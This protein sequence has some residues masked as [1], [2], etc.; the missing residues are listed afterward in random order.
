MGAELARAEPCKQGH[1][2]S[3]S[4]HDGKRHRCRPCHRAW[5]RRWQDAATQ[6]YRQRW[7]EAERVKRE[8]PLTPDQCREAAALLA[9]HATRD[10]ATD[11]LT[12]DRTGAG[13]YGQ[14]SLW[15]RQL[16]H[17]LAWEVM[18]GPIP[19]GLVTDH[20]CRN[21]ACVEV[22][23][24]RIVTRDQ[25]NRNVRPGGRLGPIWD[26]LEPNPYSTTWVS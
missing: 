20:L 5:A 2:P 22:E 25:N 17:R 3:L 14:V 23:H 21:R 1:D 4:Y 15:G 10:A 8:T 7:A 16:A 11:C 19:D 24:L 18:R 12:W 13:G 6:A 9:Q 26:V